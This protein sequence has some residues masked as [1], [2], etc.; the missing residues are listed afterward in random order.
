ME[1][2]NLTRQW[3]FAFCLA[4]RDFKGKFGKLNLSLYFFCLYFLVLSFQIAV[5]LSQHIVKSCDE[6]QYVH[7]VTY[8]K[9]CPG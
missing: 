9:S 5:K 3:N 1:K 2:Q 7:C 8:G 6:L 4:M